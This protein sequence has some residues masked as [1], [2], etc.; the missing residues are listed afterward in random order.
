MLL[1]SYAYGDFFCDRQSSELRGNKYVV[2]GSGFGVLESTAIENSMKSAYKEFDGLCDRVEDCRGHNIFVTPKR[3]VCTKP[4]V[5]I[6]KRM[7]EIEVLGSITKREAAIRHY[8]QDKLA[9]FTRN[10]IVYVAGLIIRLIPMK[11]NPCY[12]Y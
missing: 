5:F 8:P 6:C 4:S 12:P 1:S 3:T 7:I 10:P 9:C 2:C 11:P